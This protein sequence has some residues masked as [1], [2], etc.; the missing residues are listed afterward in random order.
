MQ[1]I[2]LKPYKPNTR[3]LKVGVE[4]GVTYSKGLELIE[5][6]IARDVT[7]QHKAEIIKKRGDDTTQIEEVIKAVK[8]QEEDIEIK[9]KAKAIKKKNN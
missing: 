6:G 5:K 2:L 9:A 4:M 3:V 8:K 1:V 7:A